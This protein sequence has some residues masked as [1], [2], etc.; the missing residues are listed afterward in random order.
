MSSPSSISEQGAGPAPATR[1]W[2]CTPPGRDQHRRITAAQSMLAGN[3]RL[4]PATF[5]AD[6]HSELC[7]RWTSSRTSATGEVIDENADPSLGTTEPGTELTG[8]GERVELSLTDRLDRI[9]RL[10]DMTEQEL[11]VVVRFVATIC[12]PG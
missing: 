1:L 3:A 10:S 11:R 9:E 6:W 5:I 7:S 4:G 8:G 12:P 2:L